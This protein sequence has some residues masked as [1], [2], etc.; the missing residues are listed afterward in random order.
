ML[1]A[2]WEHELN[3]DNHKKKLENIKKIVQYGAL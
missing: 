2:F 3:K 1:S